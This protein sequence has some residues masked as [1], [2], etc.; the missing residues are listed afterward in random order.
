MGSELFQDTDTTID[1]SLY[2]VYV[3]GARSGL[4]A[5]YQEIPYFQIKEVY[6]ALG[7]S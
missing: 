6:A 5:V 3:G 2:C 7:L 1:W 4:S